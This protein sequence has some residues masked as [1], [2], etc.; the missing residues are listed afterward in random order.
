MR[1]FFRGWRR[2]VGCVTLVM[3]CALALNWA[4]SYSTVNLP[5]DYYPDLE[6]HHG[7]IEYTKFVGTRREVVWQ[8]PYSF[9]TVPLTLISAYLILRKPR[10]VG[11]EHNGESSVQ[12]TT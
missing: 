1:E 12:E 2:K 6:S 11:A 4:A 5:E 3:A 9:V 8:I 10:K 7:N